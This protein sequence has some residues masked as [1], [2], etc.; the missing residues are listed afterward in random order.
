MN[1]MKIIAGIMLVVTFF[2]CQKELSM[3]P[4]EPPVVTDN[5][6]LLKK[7]VYYS[8]PDSIDYFTQEYAY[9]KSNRVEK[10]ITTV[11]INNPNN[12]VGVIYGSDTFQRDSLG[13]VT[14]IS[15]LNDTSNTFTLFRYENNNSLRA[16]NATHYLKTG[17]ASFAIDSTVFLYNSENRI[18]RFS[19]YFQKTN[20]VFTLV[21]YQDYSYDLKGN[22]IETQLYQDDNN[23]GVL[24]PSLRYTWE[25]DNNQNPRFN[26]DAAL[27]YLG[28]NWPTV[29]SPANLIRQKND[30]PNTPDDE[31]NYSY[32]YNALGKPIEEKN[33]PYDNSITKYFYY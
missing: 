7:V 27:F 17:S 12:T 26:N 22:I 25:Y 11:K 28:Y 29:G 14:I 4:A 1:E 30:Y 18:I 24:V 15:S 32:K 31:I 6:G 3:E 23:N 19:L 21:S 13:R 9:D 5:S 20:N 16:A 10:I 2:S 33:M 8:L